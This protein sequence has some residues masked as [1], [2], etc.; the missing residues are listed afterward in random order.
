MN[1]KITQIT[2]QLRRLVD[3]NVPYEPEAEFY[4]L[5]NQIDIAAQPKVSEVPRPQFKDYFP[6]GTTVQD[7]HTEFSENPELY[8]Y[9]QA[10]DSY[11]D[12]IE[13]QAAQP[14]ENELEARE[15]KTTMEMLIEK[16]EQIKLKSIRPESKRTGE[17]R[18]G[19]NAAIDEARE[20]L[21]TEAAYI[22][23]IGD[24]WVSVEDKPLYTKD[25]NGNWICT[26][27][28]DTEFIAA[29]P[30]KDKFDKEHWWIHHCVVE[31]RIGLCVV[32]D[33][34]NEKAGWELED[35][36]HYHPLPQTPNN[37]KI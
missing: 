25:A 1:N 18:I 20:L 34:D 23:A 15:G 3:A 31:D 14:L 33:G 6:E 37:N 11:I 26:E 9:V 4:R 29:V 16:L 7:I 21:T 12:Y 27:E 13:S 8:Q 35:V 28:G 10:L 30:Y 5:L 22:K 32:G 24:G 19:L 17:Y 36:T 2:A